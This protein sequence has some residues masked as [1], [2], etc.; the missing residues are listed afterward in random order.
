M[1]ESGNGNALNVHL[2][3][4]SM[5]GEDIEN[6]LDANGGLLAEVLSTSVKGIKK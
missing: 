1:A 3:C 2:R 5:K 4:M 6:S